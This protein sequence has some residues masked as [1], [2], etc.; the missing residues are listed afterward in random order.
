MDPSEV[1]TPQDFQGESLEE[2]EDRIRFRQARPGDHLCTMY[3]CANCQ[4]INIR[5]RELIEGNIQDEAFASLCTR[6]TLDAF[7]SRS[8]S[9][10]AAHR[11]EVN[12]LARYGDS[13]GLLAMPPLGP[14][15]LGDHQGML[16][17]MMLE[18]RA[19]EKGRRQT[20][21]MYGTAR[22]IRATSTVLWEVSPASGADI[23]LSSGS[24]KGRYTATMNPSEGKFYERINIGLSTRLGDIVKQD[25]AYTIEV[26]HA[27]LQLW[28]DEFIAS[29]YDMPGLEACMFF[30]A[31]CTGGLRGYE[32]V[33]TD[34][35]ALIYDVE[36]C[37]ERDDLSAVAWPVVGRFKN[38]HGKWGHYYIP[39]AGK[40]NSGIEVFK[41]TQRFVGWCHRRGRTSGWAFRKSDG[42][43]R[44]T[45]SDYA[46]EI[47]DK[48]EYLQSTT[49][50]IDSA[51][52]VREDYG[53]MRSARRFFDTHCINMKVSPTDIEVQCRWSAERAKGGVTVHRSMVQTYAEVRNML[54]TLLRPSQ[55][56]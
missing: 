1:R 42:K 7:W 24:I 49:S 54:P 56:I 47:F 17:G 34:I 11:R 26:V 28:E 25:R 4:S 19:L 10:V 2:D 14:F 33:W 48:L 50:L 18:A 30:L 37:E 32:T 20:T 22:S 38:Q 29:G 3:Q 46:D 16:Q 31:S 12:F 36:Y 21:V 40:T 51:C 35:G 9:T 55:A 39:I 6:A 44:A 41:W 27:M 52:Q 15:P 45:A 53:M 23:T 5:G 13:L 8:S 43:T